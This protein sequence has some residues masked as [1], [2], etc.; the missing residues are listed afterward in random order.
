MAPPLSGENG[1][2]MSGE[3]GFQTEWSGVSGKRLH[4]LVKL[5]IGLGLAGPGVKTWLCAA[6]HGTVAHAGEKYVPVSQRRLI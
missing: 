4:M 2:K 5:D 1:A 6:P 3:I